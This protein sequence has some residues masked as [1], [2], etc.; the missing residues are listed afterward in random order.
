MNFAKI[1]AK[2]YANDIINSVQERYGIYIAS[3]SKKAITQIIFRVL[4]EQI[5]DTEKLNI[6]LENLF[7]NELKIS[8]HKELLKDAIMPFL[9]FCGLIA[10]KNK[11]P[12]SI[13]P[14]I[15]LY[16]YSTALNAQ[17]KARCKN[18]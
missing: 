18:V 1:L 7:E 6:D 4:D 11:K 17:L 9:Y 13:E 16:K 12:D 3:P 14:K 8:R 10:D 5:T 15:N 2:K